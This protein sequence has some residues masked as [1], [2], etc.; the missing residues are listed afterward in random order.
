M[1]ALFV[2]SCPVWA[3]PW[4]VADA[5]TGEAV[6]AELAALWPGAPVEIRVGPPEDVGL[7]FDGRA[8]TLRGG[9]R[10][11]TQ[12]APDD[13]ATWVVLARSWSQQLATLD[14][15]WIPRADD[16]Q[17][18][19]AGALPSRE[20]REHWLDV[21]V[22]TRDTLGEPAIL[23]GPRLG[24]RARHRRWAVEATLYVAAAT[25]GDAAQPEHLPTENVTWRM[26]T[27]S[28]QLLASW[29]GALGR[30]ARRLAAGP[31][32]IGGFESRGYVVQRVVGTGR[33]AMV[34]GGSAVGP[35]LGG[36]LELSWRD[37][38]GGRLWAA[39]RLGFEVA[40]SYPVGNGIH[41]DATALVDFWI[42]G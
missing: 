37:L 31:V 29:S 9:G 6:R 4:W 2:L 7:S 17:A 15:G 10:V 5:A 12:E 36:G 41:H 28:L 16:E 26:D 27:A 20:R 42:S 8:L 32:L 40:G 19:D 23:E 25:F 14:A 33:P 30:D 11:W 22:G 1:P 38:L 39:D 34:G 21:L 13:P 24:L 3:V 18:P 35:V